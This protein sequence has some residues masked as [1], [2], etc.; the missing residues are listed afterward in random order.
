MSVEQ[1]TAELPDGHWFE[2]HRLSRDFSTQSN[3]QAV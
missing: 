2:G 1:L 3:S